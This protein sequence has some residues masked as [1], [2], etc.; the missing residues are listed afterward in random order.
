MINAQFKGSKFE[1]CCPALGVLAVA[2]TFLLLLD[3]VD[4]L[5]RSCLYLIS[6]SV[7][8]QITNQLNKIGR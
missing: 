7:D 3:L 2:K 4:Q 5:M 8:S 6:Q 1:N